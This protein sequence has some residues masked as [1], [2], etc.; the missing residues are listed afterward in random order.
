MQNFEHSPNI[1]SRAQILKT[2]IESLRLNKI[3]NT[4]D[5]KFAA[6]I[7]EEIDAREAE[8]REL[9]TRH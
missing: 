2:E 1:A 3:A 9:D 7:Q 8:L 4:S 6:E 5:S